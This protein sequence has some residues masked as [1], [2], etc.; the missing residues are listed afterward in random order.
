M[1]GRVIRHIV[2]VGFVDRVRGGIG[3]HEMLKGG[4]IKGEI[5]TG[6]IVVQIMVYR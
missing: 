3:I 2:D 4:V 5:F 6:L 1:G